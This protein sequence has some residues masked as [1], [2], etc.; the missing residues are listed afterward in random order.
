[1]PASRQ[2]RCLVYGVNFDKPAHL[3]DFWKGR[4]IT[5]A[6]QGAQANRDQRPGNE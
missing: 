1:M 3:L 5:P 2:V 4:K 6:S